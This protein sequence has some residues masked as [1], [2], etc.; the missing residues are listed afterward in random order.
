ML[1]NHHANNVPVI[2]LQKHN[3]LLLN[4][5]YFL[6]QEVQE[7]NFLIRTLTKR[8]NNTKKKQKKQ[9]N[10]ENTF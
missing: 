5:V 9:K 4:E 1:K 6:R 3:G 8:S 7:K 10:A 2:D